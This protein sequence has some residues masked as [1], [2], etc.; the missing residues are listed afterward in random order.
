MLTTKELNR[1]IDALGKRTAT[2]R[3][4]AQT[5]LVACAARAYDD[6][7]KDV[8]GFTRLIHKM[9]GSDM[10]ALVRWIVKHAPANF[11]KK[12]ETPYGVGGFTYN[13]SFVG[14]YDALDL[15]GSPWYVMARKPKDVPESVNLDESIA[16][17]IKR[18]AKAQADGL[19]VIGHGPIAETLARAAQVQL[20]VAA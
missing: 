18:I 11:D 17:L 3:D 12:K 7:H 20:A 16:S 19:P 8:D 2:W 13:K 10:T 1:K 5:V 6:T 4:E 14:E 9:E 15:L